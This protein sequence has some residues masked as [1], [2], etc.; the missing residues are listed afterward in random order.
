MLLGD[1]LTEFASRPGGFHL[2]L[3]HEYT[4]KVCKGW[5][6]ARAGLHVCVCVRACVRARARVRV[7]VC[8]REI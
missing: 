6:R 3:T 8:L 5:G 7:C 2:L 4:R 1:S